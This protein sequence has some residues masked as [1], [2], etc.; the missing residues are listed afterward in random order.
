MKLFGTNGIRGIANDFLNCN[1]LSKIGMSIAHVLGPGPIAIACDTR[2][3]SDMLVS[4]V[5]AGIMSLGSDVHYLG[6]IPTPA[7]QY[8]VKTHDV[9]GGVM[10][11]ASHNPPEFNGVKCISSDGIECDKDEESRIES[12]FYSDLETATWDKI[13]TRTD[14]NSAGDEYIDAVIA[15]SDSELIRKA[16]LKVCLDC[17][18]GAGSGTTPKLLRKLNVTVVGLNCNPDGMF[19]GHHSEPLEKNLPQLITLM[20]TG[21]Y[22]LG[23]AHDGDADRCCFVT[24]SGKYLT[25]DISLALMAGEAVKNNGGKAV[26]T[27]STSAIVSDAVTSAGGTIEYTAVGSPIVARKMMQSGAIIGG[28][29]NGGAI[30]GDHQFCRDGAMAIVKMLELIARNGNLNDQVASLPRY[31]TIKTVL[32]CRNE[33]KTKVIDELYEYLKDN[34]PNT[35][36]GI[37]MDYDDGWAIMRPSGTEPKFR[38]TTESKDECIAKRR[39]EELVELYNGIYARL[40]ASL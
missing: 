3:S 10:I 37:R 32:E 28:E 19:P 27:V 7:L 23:A 24:N 17:T 20:K 4:A 9:M 14:V 2:I 16:G 39:S 36:D 12:A 25:G 8:Y 38:I 18:N 13:G 33:L 22:D 31:H 40:E 30:F 1:N 26:T 35:L 21:E 6:M 11:T 29:D 34:N 15:S 5:S